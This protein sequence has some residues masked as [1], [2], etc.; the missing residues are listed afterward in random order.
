MLWSKIKG[1]LRVPDFSTLFF[2]CLV[3]QAL[4]LCLHWDKLS[5]LRRG[6]S[7]TLTQRST[8]ATTTPASSGSTL[9]LDVS[10][11]DGRPLVN[12]RNILFIV[13]NR[14]Q[15]TDCSFVKRREHEQ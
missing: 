4:T 13:F 6:K 12:Q 1:P 15:D 7:V 2:F 9:S 10:M 11:D 5:Q 14:W 3:L 8:R